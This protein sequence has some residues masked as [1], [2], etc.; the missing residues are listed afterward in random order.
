[1]LHRLFQIDKGPLRILR[2][3]VRHF[4]Y[5]KTS[6]HFKNDVLQQPQKAQGRQG[7]DSKRFEN[8]I[9]FNALYYIQRLKNNLAMFSN[10]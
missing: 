7:F 10:K 4:L 9:L 5:N 3:C 8:V 2:V 1:M 6:K